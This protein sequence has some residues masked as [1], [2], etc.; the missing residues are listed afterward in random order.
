MLRQNQCVTASLCRP[1]A[2]SGVSLIALP[3]ASPFPRRLIQ[4]IHAARNERA[5]ADPMYHTQ[6][7]E[8]QSRVREVTNATS[9][10]ARLS[11]SVEEVKL[12]IR[13]M[14][15]VRYMYSVAAGRQSIDHSCVGGCVAQA[16]RCRS[17]SSVRS[18]TRGTAGG[19]GSRCGKDTRQ[20]TRCSGNDVSSL[21]ISSSHACAAHGNTHMQQRRRRRRR[22]HTNAPQAWA[23]CSCYRT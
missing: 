17:T 5:A 11:R 9:E 10:L 14:Q 19:C 23:T 18:S 16:G 13:Q 1:V 2:Q 15:Q 8:L 20:R 21:S 7:E 3:S 4:Q 6:S 22:R 12:Q